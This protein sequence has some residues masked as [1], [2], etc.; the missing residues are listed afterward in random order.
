MK[1][2][3][4]RTKIKKALEA[5]DC[6]VA[7]IHQAG[8]TIKGLSDLVGCLPDGQFFSLEVKIPGRERTLTPRQLHVLKTI[9]RHGGIA[10]MVT[11]VDDA[12][13]ALGLS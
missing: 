9:T 8:Y 13:E 5:E 11:S 7:V 12:L 1:E 10:E 3:T 6:F 4:L 2:S